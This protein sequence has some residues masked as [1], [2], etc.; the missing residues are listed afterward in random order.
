MKWLVL[1]DLQREAAKERNVQH[2]ELEKVAQISKRDEK[3]AVS[4]QKVA[5]FV[6]D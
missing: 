6:L 4:L 5:L 2:V 3:D 1:T